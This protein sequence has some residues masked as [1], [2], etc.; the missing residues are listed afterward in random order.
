MYGSP[1][2]NHFDKIRRIPGPIVEGSRVEVCSVRPN[3]GVD[4]VV[5]RGLIEELKVAKRTVQFACE[6]RQKIDGLF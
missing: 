3:Q 5:K 1:A 2:L 6:D 4:F